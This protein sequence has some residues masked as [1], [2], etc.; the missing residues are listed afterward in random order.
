VRPKFKA[1]SARVTD[2]TTCTFALLV[3]KIRLR[4]CQH[5]IA[6]LV[7]GNCSILSYKSR[8][9]FVEFFNSLL[10]FVEASIKPTTNLSYKSRLT[11]VE[12]FNSLLC[13]VEAS[14]KPTTNLS[15]RSQPTFVEFFNSLFKRSNYRQ[16]SVK[17]LQPDDGKVRA[18]HNLTFVLSLTH[19]FH[20]RHSPRIKIQG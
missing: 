11:F 12:F 10:C 5:C 4:Q 8:L 17:Q 3:T 6:L 13:F 15:T 18:Y 2:V 16:I 19:L 14:I 7:L 20:H 9:T 1:R